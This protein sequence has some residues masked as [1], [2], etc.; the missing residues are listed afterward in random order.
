MFNLPKVKGICNKGSM[1][2]GKVIYEVDNITLQ[3]EEGYEADGVFVSCGCNSKCFKDEAA[4][5][6]SENVEA[7]AAVTDFSELKLISPSDTTA[8]ESF[9][10]SKI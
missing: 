7:K 5:E 4:V 10:I 9:I 3:W 6:A 2:K 8:L 1:D